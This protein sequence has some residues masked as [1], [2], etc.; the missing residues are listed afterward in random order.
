M[1][2]RNIELA[3]LKELPVGISDFATIFNGNY[4]YIDKTPFIKSVFRNDSPLLITR[5]RGFG[6]TLTTDTFYQFLKINPE[7]PSDASYQ[8]ELFK[9]T[10]IYEDGDFCQKFMGKWPVIF[11]SFKDV[12]GSDFEAACWKLAGIIAKVT[13]E[14]KYLQYSDKLDERDKKRFQNLLDENLLMASPKLNDLKNSL[15]QLSTLLYQHYEKKVIV[16]IDEYDV[17]VNSANI[18]GYCKDMVGLIHAMLSPVLKDNK[19]LKKGVLTGCL[20]VSNE[21]IFTGINNLKVNSVIDDRGNLAA[22]FGFTKGE[23]KTMLSYYGLSEHEQAVKDW[24]DGYSICPS[25]IF[26]S[27]DVINFVNDA[28]THLKS[29]KDAFAPQSYW[30]LSDATNIIEQ[31]MSKLEERQADAM[32]NLLDG[33]EFE[34]SLKE[35]LHYHNR[36][37]PNSVEDF[38][39]LLLHK[40]Y[41]TAVNSEYREHEGTV[42]TVRIPNKEIREAFKECITDYYAG[43]KTIKESSNEFIAEL[44][45]GNCIDA[46]NILKKKLK[47]FVSVRDMATKATPENYY[48]GFLN[49]LFSALSDGYFVDYDS[50]ADAGDGYADIM[51]CSPDYSLGVVIELKRTKDKAN[52]SQLAEDALAQ[53]MEKNYIERFDDDDV[54]KV[55]CYGIAFCRRKCKV[56]SEVKEI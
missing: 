44:L 54:E 48:H 35:Q 49:G 5:P 38:W 51:F 15:I 28:I 43:S 39:S 34:F 8:E 7:N 26:C 23:V 16:L 21:S 1:D 31:F 41:L 55:Y 14:H 32:Q 24:Y 22:C 37:T 10:K 53:I 9:D 40:G 12:E 2:P 25:E 42:C 3:S 19:I 33:G 4:Y 18:N 30:P 11:V 56:R 6:K 47:K 13:K 45:A 36:V 52:L 17:P 46:E 27:K 50:N 29:G 20:Q